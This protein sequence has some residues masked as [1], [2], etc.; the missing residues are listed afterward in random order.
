MPLWPWQQQQRLPPQQ[1]LRQQQ[2]QKQLQY[3]KQSQSLLAGR[4]V[5]FAVVEEVPSCGTTHVDL[6]FTIHVP[7]GS[8]KIFHMKRSE[9]LTEQEAKEMPVGTQALVEL[10]Q[11]Q[12]GAMNRLEPH[13][14]AV[15]ITVTLLLCRYGTIG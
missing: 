10:S 9:N 7:C 15:S 12:T 1:Q 3:Q 2:L 6:A 11:D 5:Y 14:L 8:A 13:I 4:L